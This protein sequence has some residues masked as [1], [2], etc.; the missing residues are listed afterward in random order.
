MSINTV[1]THRFAFHLKSSKCNVRCGKKAQ[2]CLLT[3]QGCTSE[4]KPSALLATRSYWI[5]MLALSQMLCTQVKSELEHSRST[6]GRLAC[7]GLSLPDIM[8]SF[9]CIS[10]SPF[11]SLQSTLIEFFKIQFYFF[12]LFSLYPA[13]CPPPPPPLD[14]SLPQSILCIGNNFWGSS[15][16]SCSGP[17]RR[18]GCTSV[19]YVWG[20]LGPAC[21]CSLIGG[22]ESE[23]PCLPPPLK[24]SAAKCGLNKLLF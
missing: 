7:D 13:H 22:S 15:C 10:F 17:T 19:T 9:Y 20:S 4:M 1:H 23:S 24:Y 2:W 5:R 12:Y 3:S 21:V 11:D 6:S 8:V 14:F 18:S 16:P